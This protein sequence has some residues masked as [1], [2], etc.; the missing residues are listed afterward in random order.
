M[1]N[2]LDDIIL[3]RRE[4]HANPELSGFE[5]K[6][7]HRIE[8]ML[9]HLQPDHL[10]TGIGGHGLIASFNGNGAGPRIL[11]R[12]DIDAL[13]IKEQ[14]DHEYVSRFDN[15]MHACGH[16]GHT[17]I[18]L[19][20]AK[21]LS[22]SRP[23]VGS[24]HLLFQ[25]AEETGQGAAAVIADPLF[26]LSPDYVFA[27]HNLPGFET[28]VVVLKE[29]IFTAAVNSLVIE[30]KG[31]TAHAAEPETGMNPALAV[32]ALLQEADRLTINKPDT[33]EFQLVTPICVEMGERAYGTAAANASLHFTLRSWDNNRLAHLEEQMLKKTAELAEEFGLSFSHY[34]TERFLTNINNPAAV[35]IVKSAAE[36]IGAKIQ[37]VE[38]PFRWGEDFGYFS[39]R[40]KGCMFGLGAGKN[41]PA[42]HN[43]DYD[44]P[45]EIIP[46]GVNM[47]LSIISILNNK[48]V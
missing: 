23:S 4:L 9:R 28:G 21:S 44:F 35:D 40:Y 34:F 13:P 45:D 41:Q 22:E 31:K 48:H 20:V 46:A 26:D 16:D 1:V 27:L 25:P 5:Y 19:G 43:P 42:L 14:N 38:A 17:A 10:L 2:D 15:S 39:S 30:L 47:F 3:L 11:I 12:A 32:A 7:A 36:Q 37:S 8:S 29:N 6:T 18:L 24:V 33:P